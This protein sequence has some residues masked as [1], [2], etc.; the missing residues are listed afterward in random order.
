[1]AVFW[2]LAFPIMFIVIFGLIFADQDASAYPVGVVLEEDSG[3]AALGFFCM[4]EMADR[5]EE[6]EPI[7]S[8]ED[9]ELCAAWFQAAQAEGFANIER[10]PEAAESSNLPLF[11]HRGTLDDE[12]E[13]LDSG[14][15]RAVIVFSGGFGEQ[16]DQAL[17]GGD[18]KANVQVHYDASQTTS[19]QIVT[20]IVSSL[21]DA[22]DRQLSGTTPILNTQLRST[23]ADQFNFLD[24]FVPGVIAV[25]LMQ[26]GI[27]GALTMVSLRERKILKRLGATPLPRRTLVLSQVVLRLGIAVVQAAI[28][29]TVG[30]VAYNVQ[31]GNQ[32]GPM[33]FFILLG[34]MTFVAIGY[35]VASFARTEAAGNAIVQAIQFPMM[36]LSGVYFPVDFAPDWL[37]P[38]INAMPLTYLGDALRQVMVKGSSAL[39]PLPVNAAVLTGWLVVSLFIAFRYF[40]WE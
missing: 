16:V 24:F 25:S 37:R 9:A 14:D 30:R 13:K 18:V 4:F 3:P 27:F 34:G 29:L 33:I 5:E 38:V 8:A 20:S 15:R 22:Y 1:M 26:L 36:F 31:V 2:T 11:I 35:L 23:T 10:P 7:I 17:S 32:I 39:F 40:R 12:L 28:I 19:A 6:G 21:L